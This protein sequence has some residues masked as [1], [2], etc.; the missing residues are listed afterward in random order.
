MP[1]VLSFSGLVGWLL[2]VAVVAAAGSLATGPAIPGWYASLVKPWFTP[3]SWLFGP[4]W[5]ALY[6]MMAVAAWLVWRKAGFAAAGL[7][8]SVFLAQLLLNGMWSW[9]FF[10]SRNIGGGLLVIGLLWLGI[11]ATILLFWRH[12]RAAGWLLVPYLAWVSFASVLN[13]SLWVLNRP[14]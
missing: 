1:K 5:T 8:L 2:A 11:L 10:G 12:S 9:V 13:Y 14:A 7:A 3:P 6:L 4:V